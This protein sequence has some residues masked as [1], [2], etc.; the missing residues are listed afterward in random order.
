MVRSVR[1]G[2]LSWLPIRTC[3]VV[4]ILQVQRRLLRARNHC[5]A[6]P[7][8]FVNHNVK[9][10]FLHWHPTHKRLIEPS[11]RSYQSNPRKGL[12]M[13]IAKR[14][15]FVDVEGFQRSLFFPEADKNCCPLRH[16]TEEEGERIV[17]L[18]PRARG[19]TEHAH[20]RRSD[21]DMSATLLF[22]MVGQTSYWSS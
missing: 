12:T 22:T 17:E 18:D 5:V 11:I 3:I 10:I 15:I 16:Y 6:T 20:P 14:S 21:P 9:L 8:N 19:S 4:Y 7:C 13:T 2:L 1:P